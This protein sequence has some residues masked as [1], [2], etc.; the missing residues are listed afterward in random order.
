MI[1]PQETPN[2]TPTRLKNVEFSHFHRS[3][4]NRVVFWTLTATLRVPIR[5][6]VDPLEENVR[7]VL[8]S[9]CSVEAKHYFSLKIFNIPSQKLF[10]NNSI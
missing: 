5:P 8:P 2:F 9:P 3:S 7:S 1:V 4:V 6:R 10:S